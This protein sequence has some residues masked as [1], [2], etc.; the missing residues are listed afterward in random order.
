M[1][2]RIC[3]QDFSSALICLHNSFLKKKFLS[4]VV[5][6]RDEEV[7]ARGRQIFEFQDSRGYTLSQEEKKNLK[8]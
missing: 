8:T 5:V 3:P 6:G 1:P 7:G 2:Q 4:R